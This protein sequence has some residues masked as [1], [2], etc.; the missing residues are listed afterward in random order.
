MFNLNLIIM[1]ISKFVFTA[2]LSAF[3]SVSA[4]VASGI[5]TDASEL[6]ANENTL[7]QQ[8]ETVLS[9]IPYEGTAV[10]FVKFSVAP[11]SGLKIDSVVCV[12]NVLASTV[13]S[14]LAKTS[15]YVPSSL[16]GSYLLKVKF[17]NM[18]G[19]APV[20]VSKNEIIRQAI[21]ENLAS[22]YALEGSSIEVYFAVKDNNIEVKK[23]EG[24]EKL[25]KSVSLA[26]ANT[27]IYDN[28]IVDGVYQVKVKF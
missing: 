17:V 8:I 7:R 1:K 3:I 6:K 27:K 9:N 5:N 19:F 12:D 21:S 11:E 16:N 2:F 14:T 18:D 26:L 24:D 25:V 13:K 22:V 23:V 15:L 4:V 20:A 28:S 10:V